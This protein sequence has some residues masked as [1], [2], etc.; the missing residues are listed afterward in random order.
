MVEGYVRVAAATPKIKVADVEYNK[1]AI[2]KMMDEAE[3][4][5]VQ[6]LV[7]PELVLSAYTCG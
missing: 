7:F 5:G 2:M 1:Q 3:K 6:L 4:E